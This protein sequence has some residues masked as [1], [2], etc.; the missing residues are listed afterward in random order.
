VE[1]NGPITL[2]PDDT[3][4]ECEALTRVTL[5]DTI[6]AIGVRA[7]MKTGIKALTLPPRLETVGKQAFHECKSL[8]SIAFPDGV[9]AL[10]DGVL[11]D[12]TSLTSVTLPP[13]L[14][15]IGESAFMSCTALSGIQLPDGLVTLD[16]YTF[17]NCTSLTRITLPAGLKTIGASALSGCPLTQI[18]L[19][20]GLETIGRMAFAETKLTRIEI[21]N[22]VTSLADGIFTFS[23]DLAEI[24]FREDNPSF[25]FRDG[26]VIRK[27]DHQ[28]LFCV[29]SLTGT[30][31]VPDVVT[32]IVNG[33]FIDMDRI[34]GVVIPASVTEL[35]ERVFDASVGLTTAQINAPITLLPEGTFV[36]CKALTDVTLP[37][38]L[39]TIGENAF[40]ESGIKKLTLPA[41]LKE[42]Q[43]A[44]FRN[45]DNLESLVF[46]EGMQ[47]LQ[48]KAI[49]G[50]PRLRSVTFPASVKT[51]GDG[52]FQDCGEVVIH[53]PE[54]SYA[55][56]WALS[57]SIP[58]E[59]L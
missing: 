43:T 39:E 33:G 47:Q 18:T 26:V 19:P 30:V 52:N 57:N 3:F 36:R 4:F 32:S 56:A 51:I 25:M 54:G 22:S 58:V 53:A 55:Y 17:R 44:A 28:M 12:C 13:N 7:F 2:L 49:S 40:G 1:I 11:W 10:P 31:R 16:E 9:T 29:P 35:G 50:C 45:C 37:D 42:V 34:T 15:A 59:P 27:T 38:T 14:T 8:E 46:P 48:S 21:P 20:E 41:Q 24:V 6:T 23:Y 5:P